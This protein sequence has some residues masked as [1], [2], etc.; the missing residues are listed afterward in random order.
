MDRQLFDIVTIQIGN[1]ILTALNP[2]ARRSLLG[3]HC[4]ALLTFAELV[5]NG[6]YKNDTKGRIVEKYITTMLELSHSNHKKLQKLM[7]LF[8]PKSPNHPGLS[9]NG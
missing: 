1:E 4:K 2:V 6:D 3:Y 7:T 8:V 9:E 5:F